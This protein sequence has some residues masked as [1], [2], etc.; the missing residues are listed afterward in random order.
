MVSYRLRARVP[1]PKYQPRQDA[2]SLR[3]TAAV[4]GKRTISLDGTAINTIVYERDQL[5]VG[6]LIVAPAIVEQFDATTLIPPGWSARVNGYRNLI[7]AK[8]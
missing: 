4:K 3:R 2:P 6:A 5:E 1:V 8:D 7:L